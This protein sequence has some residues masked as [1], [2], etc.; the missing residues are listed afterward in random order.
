MKVNLN[1]KEYNAKLINTLEYFYINYG[2]ASQQFISANNKL[3]NEVGNTLINAGYSK[4][5]AIN[6]I[7]EWQSLKYTTEKQYNLAFGKHIENIFYYLFKKNNIN[8]DF[9]N[10]CTLSHI[11]ND[12]RDFNKFDIIINSS[13]LESSFIVNQTIGLDIKNGTIW[14]DIPDNLRKISKQWIYNTGFT[15]QKLVQLKSF[16]EDKKYFAFLVPELETELIN[17]IFFVNIDDLIDNN[18]IKIDNNL[19][20]RHPHKNDHNFVDKLLLNINNEKCISFEKF[21]KSI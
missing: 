15:R 20:S 14:R 8:F 19:C 5:E 9:S 11:S 6:E 10:G 1:I 13:Y 4:Q 16:I 2:L 18:N 7:L 12:P 21:L 17:K 3:K